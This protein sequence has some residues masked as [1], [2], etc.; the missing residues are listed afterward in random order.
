MFPWAVPV[1]RTHRK[2]DGDDIAQWVPETWRYGAAP[3]AMEG[4]NQLSADAAMGPDGPLAASHG[5]SE[6][7]MTTPEGVDSTSKHNIAAIVAGKPQ[8]TV[9][10][11]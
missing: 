2:A 3:Y 10:A 5:H 6:Y 4:M 8:L 11:H 7:T 1:R 9:P